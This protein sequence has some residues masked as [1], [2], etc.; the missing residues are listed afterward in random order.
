[1]SGVEGVVLHHTAGAATGDYPSLAVV[2]DGR[3]GLPGPLAHLGLARSGTVYVIAAGLA[4]HA[5]ASDWAGFVD[6]NA[7]FLGIEGES[8]G[9]R[10]DWTPAQRDAYPRLVAAL[11]E[12]GY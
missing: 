10:D 3:P 4:Y 2:R 9:T 6:L 8:V 5:G 7:T 12:V 1:M 11:L